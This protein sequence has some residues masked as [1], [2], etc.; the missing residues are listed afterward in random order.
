MESDS[1][2]KFAEVFGRALIDPDY[3]DALITG[4]DEEKIEALTQVG[5]TP[6]EAEA[7]L[8]FLADAMSA[9]NS[10]ATHD[11]FGIRKNAA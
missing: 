11:A 1:R 8:P 7:V 6:E 5:I 9:M 10:L 3:R 2:D 4:S